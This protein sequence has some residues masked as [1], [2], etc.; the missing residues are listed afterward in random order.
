M[1]PDTPPAPAPI[2]PPGLA[3]STGLR[4]SI[5]AGSTT[6]TTGTSL[7]VKAA[8]GATRWSTAPLAAGRSPA[9]NAAIGASATRLPKSNFVN[10][11]SPRCDV[12]QDGRLVPF[13]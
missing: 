11:Q 5:V 1:L 4:E 6:P 7:P 10:G 13:C 8:K 3:G 2:V 12:G 9:A